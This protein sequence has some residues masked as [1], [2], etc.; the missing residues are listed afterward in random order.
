MLKS[1]NR[2]NSCPVCG[3]ASPDCRYS[4]D[5]E[6]VLCHSHID[7][8][9]NHP[10][11][12]YLGVA[13]SG[14]WGKFVPRKSEAF[15][16]AVWLEKKAERERDRLEREREHAKNSL[17]IPDRDKALR[18]LSQSLGLSQHHRQAL[19]DRGL[20]LSQI[21]SGLF[22]SIS[23]N[24]PVPADI[25]PN[26][27]GVISGKIA[28]AGTGIACLAFDSEGRAIGYQVRLDNA[29]DSKYRWAKGLESSH[30][31]NIELPITHIPNGKDSGQVWLSEGILKPFVAAYRHGINAIG[32]AGGNFSGAAN[33]VKNAI[34]SYRELILCPD[35]G[36]INNPQVMLR[37]SKEIKFLESLG[38]PI[39]I[40]WWGQKTKDDDDIDEIGNL[41]S[42]EFITPSQF[43]EMGKSD[44]LPF[45]ERV[46]RLVARDRKKTRKS[47]PLPLPTKR[48][49]KIYDRSERLSLWS[50]GK[51][52]L[53]MSPTGSGKSYDAGTLNP[54]KLGVTDIIYVTNDPRNV[55]TPTLK[56][57][58]LLEGRHA[59]LYRNELGE[60][61][62]RKRKDLLD[63]YQEKDLRANCARPH[64]HAALANQNIPHG[65]ESA[66][67]CQGCQFLELCRSGKGDYDY[68]QKRAIALQSKRLIAHPASLP[69]PKSQDPENG[70]DY[71]HTALIFEESELSC[72]TT[73]KV[74]VSEK[75]VKDTIEALAEK[76]DN[77]LFLALKP[78]LIAIKKLLSEKQSNRYGI[79]GKTLREK[80]LGLIPSDIDLNR[81]KE[82]LQPDLSFL[83]PISEMGE[84]I[85]DMPIAV[86]RAFSEKDS[87]L[88][89]KAENEALKQWLPELINA[90]QGKGYLSLNH[91]ILSV[92]FPDERLQAIINEAA[93]VIFLSATDSIENLEAR[94]GLTIDLITTGGGIPENMNFIQ[95]SDLGRNGIS[96]GEGQKRRSKAILD[97]Y[98]ENDPDN[99]AFI[100]FQSHCKDE[101]D[102]TS[103]KHFVNSQGT[104]LIAGVTRLIID[105]LPCP[106]L[107][108]L[109]HDYAVSTGNDP[110]GED[111]D[112]YTRH[113]I[114]SIIKQEIGRLRAN[115]HPDR[116][117]EV[118]LLTNYDFSG[119]IP[120]NQITQVKAHE[121]TPDAESVS[122]R[123][124]R[125]ILE[126]ANQLSETG[127]KITERAIAS[128]SGLARTTVNRCREFL[129][130]IL[131]TFT[132]SNPYSNCGQAENLTQTEL[133]LINDATD[134]LAASSDDSLLTEFEDILEIF[135]RNQWTTLWGFIPIPVRDKLLNQLLAIAE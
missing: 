57:W 115:L 18:N 101:D 60:V 79:D 85:A 133:D 24:K 135:D 39:L 1:F 94:T 134:Y 70:Y 27:P 78:L 5:G 9:P 15:D 17:S 22:F 87:S 127:Q 3:E 64:T 32:A 119:L 41:E 48:E 65:L 108:S 38:K 46:K 68:L 117:F 40:A 50:K 91:G 107:E 20:T 13:S 34:A 44:P 80:L 28:A 42:I 21:E 96:R 106:N 112:R 51:Y 53:D 74:T 132:I 114:L 36:D 59:G 19:L 6:L 92:S 4:T 102:Q 25:P 121:I 73:K 93:K 82:A 103:L 122:E 98:R 55:S 124:N 130:E 111:F 113:R 126:A 45:W 63:R 8:D 90:L 104:N 52:I 61:R 12:H 105:G 16:R 26:L 100:R 109:R 125:L 37:W 131:A 77:N 58:S 95:V 56:E 29:T 120:L 72:N 97:H 69:L 110:Y 118:V 88:A 67:I 62:T 81:L 89:E 83:D 86:R 14:V 84:S 66:T 54:D 76:D 30:L 49:P 23:P 31:P 128:L 116:I 33:Q 123:T 75:D 2:S 10:D 129:D 71:S 47:L 43:L 35:A 7:F 11:W 99:T